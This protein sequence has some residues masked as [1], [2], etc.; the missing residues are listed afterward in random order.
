MAAA[1]RFQPRV[2]VFD[3]NVCLGHPHNQVSAAPDADAL[4]AVMDRHGAQRAVVYHGHAQTISAIEGNEMLLAAIEGWEPRLIPQCMALPTDASLAQ[5][6]SFHARGL[7]RSVRLHDLTGLDVPLADWVYGPLLAW[8]SEQRLP[9]WVPLPEID[10][11][12]LVALLR[13]HPDLR[14]VLVGAHYRHSLLVRPLL[15]VLPQA[16]LELSRDENLGDV[17]S[18]CAE[19]GAERLLYGSWYPRYAMGPTLY[20][21]HHTTLSDGQL[22]QVCAG[23]VERLLVREKQP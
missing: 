2:P 18:L 3:A 9:L 14:V 13:G 20:Y 5:L 21:L 1:L 22:A 16:F 17:E 15:R 10:T 7:L 23:N 8:L 4:L 12:Q 11:G 19:F 6:R